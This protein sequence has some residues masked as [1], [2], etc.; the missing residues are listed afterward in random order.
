MSTLTKT[1]SPLRRRTAARARTITPKPPPQRQ[2]RGAAPLLAT[3]TPTPT[4]RPW[5]RLGPL[6]RSP[7]SCRI[8]RLEAELANRER[9]AAPRREH[10]ALDEPILRLPNAS[11]VKMQDLQEPIAWNGTPYIL[12]SATPARTMAV[13]RLPAASAPPSPPAPVLG[14][15]KIS[16][17]VGRSVGRSI[18]ST[19]GIMSS[20]VTLQSR[21]IHAVVDNLVKWASIFKPSN[22]FNFFGLKAPKSE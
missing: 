6:C 2:A 5:D 16:R 17:S 3:E 22:F 15:I 7:E 9:S 1:T 12:V 10:A 21:C 13:A 18:G 20:D 4:N 11:K 19:P 8:A 14:M